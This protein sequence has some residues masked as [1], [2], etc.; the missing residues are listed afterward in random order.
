MIIFF[1]HVRS[2]QNDHVGKRLDKKGGV[3]FKF[4]TSQAG[5][6][7][8]LPNISRSKGNQTMNFGQLINITWEIFFFKNHAENGTGKLVPELC[9]F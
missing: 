9:F 7:I 5:Q 6:L 1:H 8:N 3:N 2:N 4:R